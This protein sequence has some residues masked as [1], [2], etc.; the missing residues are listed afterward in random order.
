MKKS[1]KFW[2]PSILL[3]VLLILAVSAETQAIHRRPTRLSR[4]T[5][6]RPAVEA[7]LPAAGSTWTLLFPTKILDERF[8]AAAVYDAPTNSLIVFGGASATTVDND[9]IALANANGIGTSNWTTVI[10]NGAP[11]SPAARTFHSAVYDAA[12]SRMIVFGGC[13]F[14]GDFCTALQNDVWVLT[15]ANGVS[16]T[17]TWVQPAPTG[18]LPPP[19]WAHAAAYD[20]VNN[21]MIIYGGSNDSGSFSDTWVLSNANGSGGTPAWTQLSPSGGPPKGQ[22]S[23]SLVYEPADNVLIEFA[24][25]KQG[26]GVDTNSVWTLSYAN[27]LG[28][29]PVWTNI[30]SNGAAG[31]P[32]KRDGHFAAYDAANNRM[33]IF[34]G[35]ANTATG[36]PQLND[37]WVLANANGIGGKPKWSRLKPAGTKPGGRTSH[38]GGY[39]SANNRLIIY[40]GG[41]WDADFFSSWV[42][43]GANGL[44]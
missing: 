2:H 7:D 41:S 10:P 20:P 36:F 21:R 28:G 42:L 35:N 16:G 32:P 39:D 26:F 27:G 1:S 38:V 31:S 34:G 13:T 23:P 44:P 19:R 30:V 37:A 43:T 33:M 14:T 25:T 15:N 29:T 8:A 5:P 24:G 4:F 3:T 22:D 12:N 18:T 9:V 17:P 11:G 6:A 40:G